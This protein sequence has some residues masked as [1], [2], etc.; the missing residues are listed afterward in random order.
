MGL[1]VSFLFATATVLYALFYYLV[2]PSRF[3]EQSIH[4]DYGNHPSL[5]RNGHAPM[6]LPTAVLDLHRPQ[7]QWTASSLVESPTPTP[8][9]MVPGVK[10]DVIV[11]LDMPESTVNT[12]V[13][14]FMVTTTLRS[15][16]HQ[17]LASS[18]RSAF[19]RDSHSL[20]R[21]LRVAL[22][23]VPY[24]MGVTEPIQAVTL[25]AINGYTESQEYPL[26]EVVISLNNPEMQVYSAKLTIIAQLTGFRYL[27]YHW[28][29]PTAI[30]VIVNI[31]LV[32]ALALVILYVVYSMPQPAEEV[33]Q[34][35]GKTID[36]DSPFEN[37]RSDGK[38]PVHVEKRIKLES[39]DPSTISD[40]AEAGDFLSVKKEEGEE[41]E[42]EL[43]YRSTHIVEE[44]D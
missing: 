9:V 44:D 27:M 26:A 11:E 4:F 12:D 31:V 5:S 28:S 30:L 3:H 19:V 17:V 15:S 32:E 35:V 43:R 2:I 37:P 40:Q 8:T 36:Q 39:A 33:S 38:P 7:H 34:L 22:W 20:V 23:V 21:W 13:G 25:L 10:Y 18:A 1:G 14:M 24:A 29:L 41:E 42:A 6:T 16:E